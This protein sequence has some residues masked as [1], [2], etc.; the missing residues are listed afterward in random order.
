[1]VQPVP[2]AVTIGSMSRNCTVIALLLLTITASAQEMHIGKIAFFGQEGTDVAAVRNALQIH[3]GSAFGRL[4]TGIPGSSPCAMRS[5]KPSARLPQTLK[6][7]SA[8]LGICESVHWLA[9]LYCTTQRRRDR[10][11]CLPASLSWRMILMKLDQG[12]T[13]RP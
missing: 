12:T 9:R 10:R 11:D 5:S 1:M 3:E 7:S 2:L 13:G 8:T 6:C 4:P